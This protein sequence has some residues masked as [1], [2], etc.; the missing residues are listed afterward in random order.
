MKK[1]LFLFLTLP[2]LLISCKKAEVVVT[3]ERPEIVEPKTVS[4]KEC[5]SY[6]KDGTSISL[7][8][9]TSGSDVS[10]KLDYAV[11]EKDKNTGMAKGKWEN[12]IL[13]LD[14]T[15][16]SEGTE[17]TRQIAFE[18]KDGK[19][20]EG[21]GEMTDEGTKFKDP[22]KLEF[23]STMPLSKTNCPQ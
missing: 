22:S 4:V 19:L 3:E 23:T 8:I 15:F 1:S 17:S 12:N 5:Y 20:V 18:L 21:Y 2:L 14:Y 10:G 7:Q 11:A 6:E 16:Q 13:L 9:E